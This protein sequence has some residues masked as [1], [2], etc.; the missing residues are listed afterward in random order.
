MSGFFL[1]EGYI[2][3]ATQLT[4]VGLGLSITGAALALNGDLPLGMV[5][6]VAAG[7]ADMFDGRIARATPSTDDQKAFGVQ[8]DTVADM[9]GFGVVPAV[10]GLVVLGVHPLAVLLMVLW[11]CAA[12]LRL[13]FFNV[14][15]VDSTGGSATYTGLPVTFAALI[16][17][18][19]HWLSRHLPHG[20][21]LLIVVYA[22]TTLAFV[23]NVPVPKPKGRAIAMLLGTAVLLTAAWLLSPGT[24]PGAH[25]HEGLET[26]SRGVEQIP[27]ELDRAPG[28]PEH[29][30]GPSE[31]KRSLV[32]APLHRPG[33]EGLL[34]RADR[35]RPHLDHGEPTEAHG[36]EPGELA[37]V[38]QTG[39][40]GPQRDGVH[41]VQR[42][43]EGAD[44]AG[45]ARR[46]EV[47]AVVVGGRQ[48]QD[49]AVASLADR[50]TEQSADRHVP[51]LDGQRGVEVDV[52]EGQHPAIARAGQ[53]IGVGI[54]RTGTRLQGAG[55]EVIE[56]GEGTDRSRGLAGIDPVASDEGLDLAPRRGPGLQPALQPAEGTPA[57]ER[58][59]HEASEGGLVQKT[60]LALAVDLLA[61]DLSGD[62]VAHLYRAPGHRSGPRV[63]FPSPLRV[64][65]D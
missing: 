13:A 42:A 16:I 54:D 35:E 27:V 33:H 32:L 26:G 9:A 46:G 10:F 44:G 62:P 25:G 34:D 29:D 45:Q 40:P 60:Q 41:R 55:E 30:G 63:S 18:T 36:L 15:G 58:H 43:L 5:C 47:E 21:L 8:I 20:E 50:L 28:Q 23:A 48:A 49:D 52:A 24:D 64:A 53:V 39:R 56:R 38:E 6:L 7:V 12:A 2:S 1:F 59:R 65:H 61:E 22:L 31:V 14:H 51:A 3:R 57:H 37:L 17:P 4:L 11:V 19:A